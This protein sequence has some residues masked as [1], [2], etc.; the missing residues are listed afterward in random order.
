MNRQLKLML[1]QLN[2]RCKPILGNRGRYSHYRQPAFF[3]LSELEIWSQRDNSLRKY[4][5]VM[6]HEVSNEG[7]RFVYTEDA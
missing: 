1:A 3:T 5:F 4:A 2:T 6:R 7:E